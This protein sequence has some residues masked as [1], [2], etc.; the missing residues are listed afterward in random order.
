VQ[1]ANEEGSYLALEG[2]HYGPLFKHQKDA[3]KSEGIGLAVQ[4][5]EVDLLVPKKQWRF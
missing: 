1:R 4:L 3:G 5:S 2:N